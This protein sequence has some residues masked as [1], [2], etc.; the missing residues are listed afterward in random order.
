MCIQYYSFWVF[1]TDVGPQK[2]QFKSLN[3]RYS[4]LKWTKNSTLLLFP[5][6]LEI[7]EYSHNVWMI[8][9][10]IIIYIFFAPLLFS[11]GTFILADFVSGHLSFYFSFLFRYL[12]YYLTVECQRFE[13]EPASLGRLWRTFTILVISF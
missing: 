2:E 8:T 9:S 13:R 10:I 12:Y 1:N 4:P 3:W 7:T 6:F 11:W 5:V